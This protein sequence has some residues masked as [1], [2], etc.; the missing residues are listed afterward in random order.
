MITPTREIEEAQFERLMGGII[1]QYEM[2]EAV[3]N[4]PASVQCALAAAVKSTLVRRDRD[5]RLPL[6]PESDILLVEQISSTQQFT[7]PS[8]HKVAS[9]R[10]EMVRTI[11]MKGK[12]WFSFSIRLMPSALRMIMEPSLF[13]IKPGGRNTWNVAAA[14][15]FGS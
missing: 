9:S 5:H 11:L 3:D 13:A 10:S 1:E 12:G 7:N 4:D 15:N 8:S 14:R 6:D 2:L